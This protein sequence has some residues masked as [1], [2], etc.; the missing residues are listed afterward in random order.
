[1]G[2]EMTATFK[3]MQARLRLALIGA[4]LAAASGLVAAA[5]VLWRAP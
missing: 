5:L 3:V 4:S 2:A 1:M